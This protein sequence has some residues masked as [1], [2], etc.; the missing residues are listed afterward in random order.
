MEQVDKFY[1]FFGQKARFGLEQ[2][3]KICVLHFDKWDIDGYIMEKE[4]QNP[5]ATS[6][7]SYV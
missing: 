2:N 7:K 5:N 4:T 6:D 1:M 3:T